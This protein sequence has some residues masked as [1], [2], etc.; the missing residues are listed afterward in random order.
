MNYFYTVLATTAAIIVAEI[1]LN[2]SLGDKVK[3]L[4]LKALGFFKR[5]GLR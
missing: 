2:Y 5:T 1:L 4:I 3:D